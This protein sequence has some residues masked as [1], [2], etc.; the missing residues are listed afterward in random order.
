M[1]ICLPFVHGLCCLNMDAILRFVALGFLYIPTRH[2]LCMHCWLFNVLLHIIEFSVAF[3]PRRVWESSCSHYFWWN[4]RT[5]HLESRVLRCFTICKQDTSMMFHCGPPLCC[6]GRGMGLRQHDQ[7]RSRC[8]N[9]NRSN[10]SPFSLAS[11]CCQC[12]GIFWKGFYEFTTCWDSAFL[13]SLHVSWMQDFRC[14]GCWIGWKCFTPTT[15]IGFSYLFVVD[16]YKPSICHWVF[17]KGGWSN[18]KTIKKRW[19]TNKNTI[20][21]EQHPRTEM[22]SINLEGATGCHFLAFYRG[23]FDG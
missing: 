14:C 21:L 16:P 11:Y 6:C 20:E 12:W 4:H 9:Q 7:L 17:I 23:W 8:S 3:H 15:W 2:C 5:W 1:W 19:K 22:L 13:I 10:I 18:P